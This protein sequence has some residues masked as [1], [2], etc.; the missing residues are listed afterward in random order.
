MK[1][2]ATLLAASLGMVGASGATEKPMSLEEAHSH[3]KENVASIQ[4]NYSSSQELCDKYTCCEMSATESCSLDS[5]PSTGSSLVLP[6][7][8]TRCIFSYSTPFAFQVYRGSSDKLLF[9]FQGG[10]ACWDEPSTNIGFCT[11]DSSPSGTSGVFDKS[12]DLNAYKDYTIVQVLYCSGD[13]HGGDTTR[14]YNDKDGVPVQ[15][16]GLANAQATLDWVKAQ[17]SA[18]LLSS[19]LS[20]L[21]V[22]GCSAGSIGAQLWYDQIVSALSF[23]DAAVVPDSYVGVFPPG[24]QGPLIEDFGFC[25]S[26]F[27][28][29]EL[30]QQC[31][32]G[33]VTLQAMNLEFMEK[34][35]DIPV[36]F[37]QSKTD[38]VQISFYIAIGATTPNTTAAI[39]PTEFYNGVNDIFELYNPQSNFV[40]YL[41]DG[42]QHCFT[43]SSVYYTA[44]SMG[45]K[46][47]GAT[48][49]EPMLY[50]YAGRYPLNEGDTTNSQCEGA[51]ELGAKSLERDDNTYC[52]AALLPK[53]YTQQ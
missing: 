15:Q 39:T 11:T 18:G 20:D 35:H 12:N 1:S 45:P 28:S 40:S 53:T 52:D 7:G 36:S 24:A 21:V 4:E 32:D 27:L 14:P 19:E 29:P 23:K 43:P 2:V 5:L 49:S 44:D 46:D 42:G 3:I 34:H 22:M 10:G 48:S 41:V 33:D 13:V 37:I 30:T 38:V 6:G 16:Q 9:Y 26:G 51:M 25:K 31:V 17:Q 8:E 47:N 50:E